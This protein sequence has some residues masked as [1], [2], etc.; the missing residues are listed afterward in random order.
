MRELWWLV[1][2]LFALAIALLLMS[3]RERG[4][5]RLPLAQVVYADTDLWQRVP[6]ILVDHQLGIV[7]KPDYVMKTRQGS[8]IPV[9]VKTGHTPA[10]PYDSHRLQLMAYGL[11]IQ[12]NYA[13]TPQYGLL[14]YPD[15][16]FRV[17]FTL[18]L[19]AQLME[20]LEDIRQIEKENSTPVRSHNSSARCRSCGY[21][22]ICDQ[23]IV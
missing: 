13:Q 4:K 8:L 14:H 19:E 11:L 6:E 7:G 22:G 17:D 3:V 1:L 18:E 21:R 5:S 15:K 2:L 10:T 9:E 23:K 20:T 16:D 12:S